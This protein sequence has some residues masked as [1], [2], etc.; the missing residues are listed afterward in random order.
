MTLT[1]VVVASSLLLIAIVPILKALAIAQATDRAVE[2]KTRSLILAQRELE[3]LKA[4]SIYHYDDCFAETSRA[5]DEGYLCT[6]A[7]DEDPNLR[8]I[9]VSVGLDRDGDNILAP[10]E[11]DIS[12]STCLARRWPGP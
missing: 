12:L 1:E 6:V 3:R 10:D 7:D 2:R 11:I 8:R 9:T 5:L 4:R